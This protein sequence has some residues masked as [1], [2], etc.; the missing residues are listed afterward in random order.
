MPARHATIID[1]FDIVFSG[2]DDNNGYI[3]ELLR[4]CIS[5][6]ISF[7]ARIGVEW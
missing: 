3:L 2:D 1:R 6:P 5:F 4:K 7:R